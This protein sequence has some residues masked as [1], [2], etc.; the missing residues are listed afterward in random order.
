MSN[1]AQ[2][3]LPE[4][5]TAYNNLFLGIHQ[6]VF[7]QKCAAA[8]YPVRSEQDAE[9]MLKTAGQ[10]RQLEQA[11]ELQK[12]GHDEHNPYFQANQALNQVMQRFGLAQ[13]AQEETLAIKQAAQ[14]FAADPTF[15]NSVL[16]LKAAEANQIQAE[17]AQMRQQSA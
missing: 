12:A 1:Q 9:W 11:G 7:F 15:Y 6:R 3:T 16:A 13:P 10:L 4:P 2:A 8:G 17:L 14:E 5:Q